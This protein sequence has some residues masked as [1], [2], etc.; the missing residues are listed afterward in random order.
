MV[1]PHPRNK[2]NAAFE[3]GL[4]RKYDCDVTVGID[5]TERG[6]HGDGIF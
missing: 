3:Q 4:T 6:M 5:F 2:E 1:K